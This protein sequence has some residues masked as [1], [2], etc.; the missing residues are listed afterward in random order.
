MSIPTIEM[1]T[2][3]AQLGG[4]IGK[5]LAEQIPQEMGRQRLAYALKGMQGQNLSP[6][7][8]AQ[9]LLASGGSM[10]DIAAMLPILQES[11]NKRIL[12]EQA[13]GGGGITPL[14]K[15]PSGA[16]PNSSD[17]QQTANGY[18]TPEQIQAMKQNRLQEPSQ[19]QLAQRALQYGGTAKEAYA[20]AKEEHKTNKAAQD[21]AVEGFHTDL[22]DRFKDIFQTPEG[23]K[24][25]STQLSGRTKQWFK[26]QGEYLVRNGMTRE[27]ASNQIGQNMQ[28]FGDA[29]LRAKINASKYSSLAGSDAKMQGI[30]PERK[31]AQQY[32]QENQFD[33]III[34][35]L[36]ISPSTYYDRLSPITDNKLKK[37][38]D[39]TVKSADK[40]RYFEK[41]VI[42]RIKPT[43]N[44][45]SIIKELI[46]Y[47]PR[48]GFFKHD[49]SPFL[50]AMRD[51]QKKGKL[52]LNEE[53]QQILKDFTAG[54]P[55]LS[56]LL[57][58]STR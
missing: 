12:E 29:I 33:K 22:N 50:T 54:M 6:I 24:D 7:D 2:F 4:N 35:E 14:S 56:D 25:Y 8:Q 17:E 20:A 30:L 32:G 11:Q 38:I 3:G 40:V 41:H 16:M 36:G 23:F 5:S 46:A 49:P 27:A 58:D 57:F 42:P 19:Q 45:Q 43:D 55:S 37:E 21:A 28:D 34:K 39:K 26:D 31:I 48:G 51:A 47:D 13:R 52:I 18:A 10:Q 53:N 44:P 1:P 15:T 9:K